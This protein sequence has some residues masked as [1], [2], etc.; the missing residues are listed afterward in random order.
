VD[1]TSLLQR[2]TIVQYNAMLD[3]A[4]N[5]TSSYSSAW[6]GPPQAFTAW[7]QAAALDN[8]VVGITS[9]T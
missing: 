5:G 3:L 4:A 6:A 1:D 7:G 9:T 8:L 2:L